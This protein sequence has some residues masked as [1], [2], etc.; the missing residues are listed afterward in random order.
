MTTGSL[1][2][3]HSHAEPVTEPTAIDTFAATAST[4]SR[5]LIIV[6]DPELGARAARLIRGAATPPS[7]RAQSVLS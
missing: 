1:A 2:L 7:R 5:R 4:M 6:S 3:A